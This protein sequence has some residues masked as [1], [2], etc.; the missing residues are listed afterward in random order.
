[1]KSVLFYIN[2]LEIGKLDDKKMAQ[3]FSIK[4]LKNGAF[5]TSIFSNLG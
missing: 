3:A 4:R 1:M 5:S 2:N